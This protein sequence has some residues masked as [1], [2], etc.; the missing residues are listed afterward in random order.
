MRE[1]C[2]KVMNIE[3]YVQLRVQVHQFYKHRVW[4]EYIALEQKYQ[5]RV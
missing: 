2:E 1:F 5:H 3:A 4:Y